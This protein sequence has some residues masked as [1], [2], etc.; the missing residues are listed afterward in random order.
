MVTADYA[1]VAQIRFRELKTR[2]ALAAFIGA[3]AWFMAPSMWPV[4]WFGAVNVAVARLGLSEP[5][6]WALWGAGVLAAVAFAFAF[7]FL[8]DW[9]LQGRIKAWLKSRRRAQPTAASVQPA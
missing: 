9:P 8:I 7:H 2:I 1:L 5:V 4:A 3:T 6:Q